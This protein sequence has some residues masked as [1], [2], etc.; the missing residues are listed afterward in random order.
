MPITTIGSIAF[1]IGTIGWIGAKGLEALG[2]ALALGFSIPTLLIGVPILVYNVKNYKVHKK[3]AD[4]RD[5]YKEALERYK[6]K[7]H[8]VEVAITPVTNLAGSSIGINAIL[9]F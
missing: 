1:L 4:K 9:S 5:E 8:S 2:A 3:R 7:Q 6:Q